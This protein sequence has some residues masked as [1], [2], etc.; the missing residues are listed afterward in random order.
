[1]TL[2][3][4][5][6]TKPGAGEPVDDF[7]AA[8]EEFSADAPADARA[9]AGTEGD[10]NADQGSASDPGQAVAAADPDPAGASPEPAEAA[11]AA[12]D[13][14]GT[15]AGETQPD[16]WAD[17]P[18]ALKE[19]FEASQ[20]RIAALEHSD[21]SNRGRIAAFQRQL[22]E[23]KAAKPAAFLEREDIKT[24]REEYPDVL[25]PVLD[26][27]SEQAEVIEALQGDRQADVL[28]SHRDAE[29]ARLAEMHPDW[30]TIASTAE[31]GSWVGQQPGYVQEVIRRNAEGIVDHEEAAD[32][33]GRYKATLAPIPN[34]TPSAKP[35]ADTAATEARRK[36]L[37]ESGVAI[38]NRG[39]GATPNA[40]DDFD[41]AFEFY[42]RDT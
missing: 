27:L 8:F 25:A 9:D 2:P 34:T 16:I 35:N 13:N 17:A 26:I 42:S 39:P 1:M 38:T 19:A 4:D 20:Q 36:R 37:L 30:L 15:P 7:D 12:P 28:N 6:G 33:I 32:V 29:E 41:A 23:K 22:S 21:R 14:A 5:G 40:P 3:N 18:P 11:A 31:F 10:T 24:A